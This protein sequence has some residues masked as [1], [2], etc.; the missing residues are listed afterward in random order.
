MTT[1]L[2]SI[3]IIM[4]FTNAMGSGAGIPYGIADWPER[5]GNHRAVVRVE[6]AA[7]AVKARIP[8]RRT[9]E[10]P[11]KKNI[12]ILRQEREEAIA[13]RVVLECNREYGV[14]VFQADE[15]G[16]YFVY[17]MPYRP[18]HQMGFGA[19]TYDS[20]SDT[21]DPK[22]VERYG[23]DRGQTTNSP[24]TAT[25]T[26]FEARGEFNR[27]DPMEI[28]ATKAETDAL[29]AQ[30]PQCK[31]LV[32]PEDRRNPIRLKHDLPLRWIQRGVMTEFEGEAQRNEF[33]AFQLGVFAAQET[34]EDVKAAC[35]DLKSA[36]GAVIPASAF[37]CFNMGGVDWTGKTF[38]KRV[39][40]PEGC[41]QPMWCGIAVPRDAQPGE[42]T[43]TVTVGTASA[44]PVSVE[45]R[46]TV[47]ADVL[48]DS[49]DSDLWRHARLRWL[50]STLGLD[51]DIV[52][53]YIPL[54][55]SGNTVACLGRDVALAPGGLP[56]S[57]RSNQQEI[58]A[59]PITFVVISDTG[60]IEWSTGPISFVHKTP[61]KVVW[62]ANSEGAA[63]TMRL[64]CRMEFDG[65]LN[66][67]IDV[68]AKRATTVQDF[69]LSIPMRKEAATY[70][71][72]M[73][74]KGG[75]RPDTWEW[76]WDKSRHQD[77]LWL[78]NVN[79][80]LQ[81]KLKGPNYSWP[82]VNIHYKRKPLDIPDAWNNDGKGGCRVLEDGDA[83]LISAYS[84]P[85][86]VAE[87]ETLQ[88]NAGLLITPVKPINY[89]EHWKTRYYHAFEPVENAAEAGAT[90]INIHHAN[91]INPYINYPFLRLDRLAAYAKQ[92]H[93]CGMK[94]KIY[95]TLREISNHMAE[96]WAIRSLGTE[97]FAD[98]PGGGYSWLQEHLRSGYIPAWQHFFPDGDVD[99]SIVTQGLSRWHNYYLEGLR[100]LIASADI[101]GL[102]LDDIGFDREVMQ[103]ARKIMDRTKPGCLIDLHS[104]NHFNDVAGFANCANLY[105]EHFPYVNSLWFGE[106]FDYNETPDYWLV[107]ISGIPFGMMSEMLQDGGNPWRGMV[108]GMT[109]RLPYCGDP[110]PLWKLWDDFAIQDARMLGYW[111]PACPAKTDHND[112][113]ITAYQKPQETLLAVA[114][115]AKDPAS[116][117][118][119]INWK[120]LGMVPGSATLRAPAVAGLQEEGELSIDQPISI[121]PGRGA[122]LII[123]EKK[124]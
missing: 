30:Y 101:D 81:C 15:P 33:Y 57:I 71:M 78:G 25:V 108:Y 32:F 24:P 65:Y 74:R 35:S 58:L 44:D 29:L 76:H 67:A 121:E 75:Y 72:G 38:T 46:L 89:A 13:N 1:S 52:A 107:E 47:N 48:E 42:Y 50:D 55:I 12:L 40:I 34:L 73:G 68:T 124:E 88:F 28:A 62:E 111:D 20:P 90:V 86:N 41:V 54:E 49:N 82:L 87:G 115:W 79:A 119:I 26:R 94:M 116:I 5:F 66:F 112:V 56:S 45:L 53:P 109:N 120:A 98:G 17:Y 70:M 69:R 27:F 2:A 31:Y 51:D 61:G 91:E 123:S 77:S 84:G 4:A 114:S 18:R 11:E 39:D 36:Q 99:A 59:A 64:T 110:K 21:A 103:R 60:P 23:L 83:V 63:F 95:Y 9:D 93:E 6:E 80:G 92:A 105:L 7:D 85:R 37:R 43:G 122:L 16:D 10:N 3:S 118:L 100:F 22:W 97:V 14:I 102:Y 113:L 104:W 96:L 106:A 117:H 8:W 19:E